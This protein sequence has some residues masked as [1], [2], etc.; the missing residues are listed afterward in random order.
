MKKRAEDV[1]RTR[2][3]ITEAA[4]RLH[5]TVGPANTTIS[6]VA[7]EAGVTRLT[8][9]NHFPDEEQLFIACSEHWNSLHPGPDPST[10][11]GLC[12]LVERARTGLAELYGWY[13]EN[14]DDFFPVYR[15][16]DAMPRPTQDAMRM[17][18]AAA[19]DALV[20]GAGLRGHAKRRLRAVAGHL[21]S[22]WTWRS[23]A[24]DQGL[25]TEEAIDVAVRFFGCSIEAS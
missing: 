21:V 6:A 16:F 10:W 19:A 22:F 11:T 17:A 25:E 24:V 1:D 13:A 8:V 5:T 18:Q 23:L 14:G 9:Y 12:N 4:V 2:R 7:E 15:D 20:Q 3:R